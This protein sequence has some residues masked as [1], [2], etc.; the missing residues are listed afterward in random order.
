MKIK[1]SFFPGRNRI[2]RRHHQEA[3]LHHLGP[4]FHNCY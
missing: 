2:H 4:I 3:Y 1:S